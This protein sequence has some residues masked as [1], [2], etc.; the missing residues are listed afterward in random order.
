MGRPAIILLSTWYNFARVNSAVS[1]VPLWQRGVAG[2]IWNIGD[3]VK[4]IEEMEP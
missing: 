4:R 3:I 2:W 1:N